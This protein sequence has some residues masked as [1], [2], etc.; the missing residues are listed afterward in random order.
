[1][2]IKSS[3]SPPP[4]PATSP[5]SN[6]MTAPRH[7]NTNNNVS[8]MDRR[9]LKKVAEGGQLEIALAELAAQQASNPDVRSFAQQLATDHQQMSGQLAQLATT[10]GQQKEIAEYAA[11]APPVGM[12]ATPAPDSANTKND[13]ATPVAKNTSSSS[14]TPGQ[15][16]AR[17]DRSKAGTLSADTSEY[18]RGDSKGTGAAKSSASSTGANSDTAATATTANASPIDNSDWNDPKKDRHYKRLAAKTGADFDKEYISMMVSDH[19]EDVA[20][21]EKESTKTSDTD[22]RAFA[23]ASL[24]KLREHLA[25]AQQIEASLK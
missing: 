7:S 22:V 15:T 19:E 10:K 21:F 6:V 24:P 14:S 1:M 9:F 16:A 25:R 18:D 3:D 13:A 8:W 23:Q 11:V 17:A 5:D 2:G 20:R 12:A 4:T